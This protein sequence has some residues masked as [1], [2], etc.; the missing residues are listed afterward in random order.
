MASTVVTVG[1][2]L[3]LPVPVLASA[4]M[5]VS[6]LARRLKGA[7]ELLLGVVM[8]MLLALFTLVEAVIVVRDLRAFGFLSLPV[9][10]L[11]LGLVLAG[12]I[13]ALALLLGAVGL[14]NCKPPLIPRS[15]WGYVV[16][17]F[18]AAPLGEELLFRGLIEGY[19]LLQG[20][21][22]WLSALVPAALFSLIHIQPY[23]NSG[24][25]CVVQVVAL[26]FLLGLVA[27][28]FRASTDS[29]LLPLIIHAVGNSP[30]IKYYYPEGRG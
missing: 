3:L 18:M 14:E 12:L 17:A 10:G 6:I 1:V 8:E 29:I 19:M 20:A 26:A 5:L 16:L 28:Y 7:S 9:G 15:L 23:R 21:G 27:G 2:A 4:S 22:T 25:G 13:A 11:A 30:G 24:L